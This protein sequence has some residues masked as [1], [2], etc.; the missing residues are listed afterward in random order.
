MN[1]ISRAAKDKRNEYQRSWNKQHKEKRKEY[2]RNYW[3]RKALEEIKEGV[4]L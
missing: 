2:M 1:E 4:N 3:E